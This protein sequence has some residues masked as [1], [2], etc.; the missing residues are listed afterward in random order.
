[1]NPLATVVAEAVGMVTA[2][3]YETHHRVGNEGNRQR[4]RGSVQAVRLDGM[5]VAS[6]PPFAAQGSS[7]N[8]SSRPSK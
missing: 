5:N 4:I 8:R 1:M 3:F 6:R 7:P 2:G